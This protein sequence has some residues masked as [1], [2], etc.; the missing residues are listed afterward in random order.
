M[1][2]T[3]KLGNK[4]IYNY[5]TSSSEYWIS[6]IFFVNKDGDTNE[7]YLGRV[8]FEYEDRTDHYSRYVA[9]EKVE[10][11]KIL[12]HIIS[13]STY[14]NTICEYELA[15]ELRDGVNL[16]TSIRCMNSEGE[17]LRPLNFS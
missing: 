9:C 17:Q 14:L 12:K 5:Y 11:N 10:E 4:T 8:T 6:D 16:L 2:K 15:H 3:D 13:E 1:E 7:S